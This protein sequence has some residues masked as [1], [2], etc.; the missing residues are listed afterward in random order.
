MASKG[1]TRR[2]ARWSIPGWLQGLL[3]V[4][5]AASMLVILALGLMRTR[6]PIVVEVDGIPSQVRTH[7][8]T[9]GAA[10]D[11]AG[12]DLYPEDLVWPDLDVPLAAN[13]VIRVQRAR[14]V[15]L[16]ANDQVLRIRTHATTVGRVL[17]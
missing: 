4:I 8:A 5:L 14:P 16:S 10:L 3:A 6:L 7:A 17:G 11:H 9:V 15:V 13:T 2:R 12:L 1:M